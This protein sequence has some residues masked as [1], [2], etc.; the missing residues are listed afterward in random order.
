M[1]FNR[2]LN[3][4]KQFTKHVSV[5]LNYLGSDKATRVDSH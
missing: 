3:E 4:A 2:S 1:I 5:R